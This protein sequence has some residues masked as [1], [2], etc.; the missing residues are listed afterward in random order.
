MTEKSKE[1]FLI[2]LIMLIS[3]FSFRALSKI[4]PELQ[5]LLF[6]KITE[7][8][9]SQRLGLEKYYAALKPFRN[10]EIQNLEIKSKAA[11][12]VEIDQNGR[13]RPLFNKNSKDRLAI[14]SLTKLMAGLIV[15]ENYNLDENAKISLKA[16]TIE[17][18]SNYFKAGESFKIKDLFYPLLMESSN[19]AAQALSE[20][21]GEGKFVEL[22]NS[23]AEELNLKD[24][25]F[26]NALGLD[27]DDPNIIPNYSTAED[28]T[29]LAW[30]LFK[31]PFIGE[32]LKTQE[33]EL[34]S[35]NGIFH[36]K[37][38]S[39]NELLE[40]SIEAEWK[41][42]IWGGK[43]GWT[44]MAGECLV[45]ILESPRLYQNSSGQTDNNT[46]LINV[47]LGSQDRFKEMKQLVDWAYQ[48]YK[49]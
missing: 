1:I 39:N 4:E 35:S 30:N 3:I 25:Y 16:A 37:V 7:K 10:W 44:P 40:S 45:F 8:E 36:H 9:N 5:G 42:R 21:V 23:K 11:I 15:L 12:S 38:E 26:L 2:G 17:G 47:I 29:I 13:I 24:T 41:Q 28:L 48:A 32:V 22:M 43:T 20:V 14:A 33:F 19:E 6:L 31:N 27:P 49:W 34:Y 46:L 18:G